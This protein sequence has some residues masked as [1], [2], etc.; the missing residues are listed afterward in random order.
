MTADTRR[1]DSQAVCA[2]HPVCPD[3]YSASRDL[4]V[5]VAS[6]HEQGWTLLCNGVIHFD[7]DCDLLPDGATCRPVN[8]VAG[9]R[10]A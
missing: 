7:D 6:H 8:R 2:H 9:R 10:V 4:A 1:S 5:V 3:A